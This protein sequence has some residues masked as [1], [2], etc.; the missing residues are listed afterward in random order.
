[1]GF[2]SGRSEV[3]MN[4]LVIVCGCGEGELFQY[5]LSVLSD[6]GGVRWMKSGGG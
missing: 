1:M 3:F 6:C 5:W 2:G 4:F